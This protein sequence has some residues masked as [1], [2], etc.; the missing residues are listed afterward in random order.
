MILII[1][2]IDI[3]G[4]ETIGECFKSKGHKLKIIDLSLGD[5]LPSN[6]SGI[7][8]VVVLGGPMNVYEETAY[9]WL[10]GAKRLIETAI[11]GGK[12]VLGI[13]LGAQLIA[14]VLGAPVRRNS[15]LE[16]GWYPVTLTPE[17]AASPA[18]SVLPPTFTAFHWHGDTFDIP[19]GAVR[20]AASEACANQAFDYQGRVFGWQ[21]HLESS[22][23]SVEAL[24]DNCGD[25]LTGPF[26]QSRARLPSAGSVAAANSL[27]EIFFDNMG[28]F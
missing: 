12:I 13:C 14:A 6:F 20:T 23:A 11:A 8:A 27:M 16:I 21:F 4:P 18:F 5:A 17:A 22:L 7:E 1:K 25:E 28:K 24:I 3:E 10:V 26:V 2:H 9:P 19:A 15:H